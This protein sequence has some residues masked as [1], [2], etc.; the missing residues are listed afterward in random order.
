MVLLALSIGTYLSLSGH[1]LDPGEIV[2]RLRDPD[3]L[4][5]PEILS[6][7]LRPGVVMLLILGFG[8]VV[9][10]IEEATKTAGIGLLGPWLR[11]SPP[12]AFLI[13]V[14]SGAGFALAENAF[15]S[16]LMFGPIWGV[17]LFSRLAATLMHCATGGLMGWG[18]GALWERRRPGRL[19]LAYAG[20]TALHAV[21]N[22]LA[23]GTGLA[24]LIAGMEQVGPGETLILGTLALLAASLLFALAV[25]VLIGTVWGARALSRAEG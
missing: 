1:G 19:V 12:R 18:W 14:A 5:D 22:G 16:P 6:L 21:W 11:P 2:E 9:P 10:L 24:G 7:L 4:A 17:G 3:L 15:N 23:V 8:L 25:A 20:A 13:G